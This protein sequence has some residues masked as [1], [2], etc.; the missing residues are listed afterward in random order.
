MSEGGRRFFFL[1]FSLPAEKQADFFLPF[2]SQ[3]AFLEDG[4]PR[5]NRNK[6]RKRQR[7]A[8]PIEVAEG[9][10]VLWLTKNGSP[11]YLFSL[12]EHSFLTG[13]GDENLVAPADIEGEGGKVQ[14]AVAVGAGLHMPP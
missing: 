3:S 14:H 2:P 8:A 1:L 10:T 5:V 12:R 6:R 11:V 4:A 7:T 13:G 9:G